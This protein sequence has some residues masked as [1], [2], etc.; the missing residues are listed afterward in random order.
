MLHKSGALA[1]LQLI[2]MMAKYNLHM[3]EQDNHFLLLIA[4]RLGISKE[5]AMRKGLQLM[6]VIAG[7]DD[8]ERL[9]IQKGSNLHE[10]EII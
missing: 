10:L 5:E 2:K 6:G 8:D 4:Y 9:L 7:F 1:Q 3:S